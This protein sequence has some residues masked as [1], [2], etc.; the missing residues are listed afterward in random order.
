MQFAASH[1]ERLSLRTG[2]FYLDRKSLS[3][4]F[5]LPIV[6]IITGP[7]PV[8][9]NGGIWRHIKIE[10]LKKEKFPAIM[11][12]ILHFTDFNID[13]KGLDRWLEKTIPRHIEDESGYS[14]FLFVDSGG[15][16]L[17]YNT[18]LDV[19]RYGFQPTV[20][21]IMGLQ[22]DFGANAVA[23]LDYPIPPG[24]NDIESKDR[25]GRSIDNCVRT[26]KASDEILGKDT[27]V[28]MCVHGRNY[29][30]AHD[31]VITLL[32]RLKQESL[33]HVP[34]GIAIGSLVPLASSPKQVIDI[35]RGVCEGIKSCDWVDA[36]STPIHAFGVSSRMMPV[37]AAIGVDTFDGTTYVQQ[38]QS[39]RYRTSDNFS[40][41]SFLDVEQIECNCR[42]CRMLRREDIEVTKDLLNSRKSGTIMFAGK[43]TIKS[44]IYA[45]IALH[46]L[47]GSI[48][49]TNLIRQSAGSDKALKRLMVLSS[50]DL[51]MRKTW[52]YLARFCPE[53][54]QLLWEIGLSV[55][56]KRSLGVTDFY[57]EKSAAKKNAPIAGRVTPGQRSERSISLNLGPDDF[58]L[59]EADYKP[60]SKPVLLILPCTQQ[61]P[62]SI[63]PTHRFVRQVLDHAGI[64]HGHYLKMTLSGNY[65]LVPE[66]FENE[67][68]VESYDFYLSS[69]D[70]NRIELLI[71]RTSRYLKKH[72]R[73]FKTVVGY[74]TTKSYREVMERAFESI[75]N[76]VILPSPLRVRKASQF[77]KPENITQLVK[78]VQSAIALEDDGAI[79]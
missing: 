32:K 66:D 39:L 34:L 54:S 41:V 44:Y 15:Y 46:N 59:N 24:L 50:K 31:T 21:G 5:F 57:G 42:Y 78:A 37:L 75:P 12:Q 45:L 18:N 62:Y 19:E 29:Q 51:K 13:R 4:P 69:H 6:D 11:T 60:P 70:H 25:I 49:L 74:S 40:Y 3:T 56:E 33:L 63:S 26:A 48:D 58:D 7:P 22:S 77:R 65:G 52:A 43:E 68:K 8:F 1:E 64:D 47:Q 67:P 73:L 2:K 76:A 17:L 16:R 72:F 53:V 38:A 27:L 35:V 9:A 71:D 36:Y 28:Y 79:I 30:E 14:P 20:K 23:S 55:I 10:L 61:K